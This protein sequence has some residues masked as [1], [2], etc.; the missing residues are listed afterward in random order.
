M[1]NIMGGLTSDEH[2]RNL[3]ADCLYQQ[4]GQTTCQGAWMS[5]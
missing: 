4:R 1:I 5:R 3:L 2:D